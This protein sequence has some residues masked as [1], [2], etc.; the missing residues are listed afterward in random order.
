MR[1]RSTR[2]VELSSLKLWGTVPSYSSL[3]RYDASFVMNDLKSKNFGFAYEDDSLAQGAN[4]SVN[5]YVPAEGGKI[6]PMS[7]FQTRRRTMYR[8]RRN[9]KRQEPRRF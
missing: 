2:F 3:V 7:R 9:S 4:T 8:W 5:S 1:R 6:P